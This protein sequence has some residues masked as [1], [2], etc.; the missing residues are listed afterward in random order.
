MNHQCLA[1]FLLF[2][3][4]SLYVVQADLELSVL[5]QSPELGLQARAQALSLLIEK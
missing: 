4:R 1:Y 3:T 2:E 5:P